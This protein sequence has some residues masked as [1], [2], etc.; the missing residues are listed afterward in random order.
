M[1]V[2]KAEPPQ[3]IHEVLNLSATTH[4]IPLSGHCQPQEIRNKQVVCTGQSAQA[5]QFTGGKNHSLSSLDPKELVVR[6]Y[7]HAFFFKFYF[8]NKV[9]YL[10]ML[11]PFAY[12]H[13]RYELS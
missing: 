6:Q 1:K 7:K 10:K 11:L 5:C 3:L 4:M 12:V 2:T 9:T 8:D 13:F